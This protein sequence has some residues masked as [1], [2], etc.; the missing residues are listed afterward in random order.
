MSKGDWRATKGWENLINSFETKKDITDPFE[1]MRKEH[2]TISAKEEVHR[3]FKSRKHNALVRS[4]PTMTVMKDKS[5]E[6]LNHRQ[7]ALADRAS[8]SV[9]YHLNTPYYQ[10]SLSRVKRT[11]DIQTRRE[12]LEHRRRKDCRHMT[13]TF[14]SYNGYVDSKFRC[15]RV[16]FEKDLRTLNRIVDYQ[17]DQH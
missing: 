1:W 16:S 10:A 4:T 3:L 6:W 7:R 5:T 15:P 2:S 9:T 11:E 12:L 17:Y 13:E 14:G 8:D